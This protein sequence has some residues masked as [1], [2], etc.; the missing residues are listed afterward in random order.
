MNKERIETSLLD[1]LGGFFQ[2]HRT[3]TY[4]CQV[5]DGATFTERRVYDSRSGDLLYSSYN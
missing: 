3:E 1:K 5:G 2:S 4:S